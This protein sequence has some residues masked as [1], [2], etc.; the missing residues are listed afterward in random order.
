M[1]KDCAPPASALRPVAT[2]AA[3]LEQ[4]EGKLNPEELEALSA[5]AARAVVLMRNY[6]QVCEQ[7]QEAQIHARQLEA[8]MTT[9]G[10]M[11]AALVQR[12]G[13]E[14]RIRRHELEAKPGDTR[15][16]VSCNVDEKNDEYV[17]TVDRNAAATGEPVTYTPHGDAN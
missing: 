12:A 9:T 2:L 3:L 10:S 11:L 14:L 15:M 1:G 16:Q 6:E 8:G 4:M 5:F 17:V 7:L 13:G